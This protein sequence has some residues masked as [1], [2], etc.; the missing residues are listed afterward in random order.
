MEHYNLYY[1]T[2][3]LEE[4][5]GTFG[6]T[7]CEDLVAEKILKVT[8]GFYDEAIY[9]NMHSV[10]LHV[11]RKNFSKDAPC[12]VKKLMISS[13][14]DEVGFIVSEIT[15]EGYLKFIILSGK[16]SKVWKAR[17][18]VVGNEKGQIKGYVGAK[19]IHLIKKEDRDKAV[20]VDE[21]YIDIG[22]KDK[23]DAEKYV[24]IGDYGTWDSD[25]EKFGQDDRMI[26]SKAIDDRLGCA[27]M[28]DVIR[29]IWP[30]RW[31]LTVDLY[32]AFTCKEEL[33][34]SGARCACNTINPDHAIILESTA[35]A[36]FDGVDES[37]KVAIQG[38]GGAVSFMDRATI[39]DREF[40]DE[41]IRIAKEKNIKC[42]YKKFVSGG[43]DAGS[44]HK[45]REGV[46]CAA[47]SA[48]SRYIHTASNVIR[49]SD[50][51]A[52]EDLMWESIMNIFM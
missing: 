44:I 49:E 17:R 39:Y 15:E 52:I 40:T 9:D 12:G 34:L 26:K 50:Y 43:N 14:M 33:G 37:K 6:P 32:F 28:C 38:E 36:D 24:S 11:K 21:L 25:F 30:Y 1:G 18:V 4:L 41:I 13:H 19:P 22:A 35:V 31:G 48:P 46:K 16:D 29:K 27:V 47:I 20:P 51:Y 23:E 42:Q 3:L 2:K 45:M 5:C 8:H 7:G 10:I